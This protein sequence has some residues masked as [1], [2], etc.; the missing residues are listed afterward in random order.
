MSDE[1]NPVWVPV[2]GTVVNW[3]TSRQVDPETGDSYDFYGR[4]IVDDGPVKRT[5]TTTSEG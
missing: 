1:Q 3:A 2:N 5:E 4:R